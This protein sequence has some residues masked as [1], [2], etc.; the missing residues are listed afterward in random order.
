[1]PF[2]KGKNKVDDVLCQNQQRAHG[3]LSVHPLFCGLCLKAVVDLRDPG[4]GGNEAPG[5]GFPFFIQALGLNLLQC[6]ACLL[7]GLHHAGGLFEHG[8][9]SL[10]LRHIGNRAVAGDDFDV[11]GVDVQNP[12]DAGDQPHHVAAVIEIDKRKH[13]VEIQITQMNDVGG[14]KM[15]RHIT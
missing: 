2:K 6:F 12:F 4:V 8:Q 14:L 10:H 1:M 9:I 11:Y 13:L 5:P 7:G 15:R 3:I